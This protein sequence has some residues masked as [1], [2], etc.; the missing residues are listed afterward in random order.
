MRDIVLGSLIVGV[1]IGVINAIV[2]RRSNQ[3]IE[4]KADRIEVLVNGHS[5]AQAKEI[6]KLHADVA[7]LLKLLPKETSE[8]EGTP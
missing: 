2:V 1:V 4:T 8:Q 7:R 5:T 6:K 3:R